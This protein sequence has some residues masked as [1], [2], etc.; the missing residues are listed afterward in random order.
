MRCVFCQNYDL[1]HYPQGN[2]ESPQR[3]GDIMI[4]LQEKGCS[5]INLVSP[6]HFIPQIVEGIYSAA[7]RGLSLPIVYNTGG[8]EDYETIKLLDGVIDIFLPDIKFANGDKGLKYTK[9][10]DYFYTAKRT[11]K[12]MH[13]QVGDLKID[14]DGLA[15]KGVLLRHLVMPNHEDDSKEILN[16]IASE[17]SNNSVV[18]IMGLYKPMHKASEYLEIS[19]ELDSAEFDQVAEY[20]KDIG[21]N[22]LILSK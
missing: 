18:D 5:N 16:F 22:R 6:T 1:S 20:A 7:S 13:R 12:E 21:L 4:E 10:K 8:Y 3:L 15:V 14:K 19:K 9:C 11:I 2:E 17:L